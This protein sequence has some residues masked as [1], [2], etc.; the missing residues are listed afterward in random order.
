MII[1][2]PIQLFIYLVYL[3][4]WHLEDINHVKYFIKIVTETF[5]CIVSQCLKAWAWSMIRLN[6]SAITDLFQNI[7]NS[8]ILS[9]ASDCAE[10]LEQYGSTSQKWLSTILAQTRNMGDT[11][12]VVYTSKL[13]FT[14]KR[15]R[16]SSAPVKLDALKA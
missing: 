16:I 8:I 1:F 3:Y 12:S 9:A 10:I 15:K 13:C 2:W 11:S 5:L 4:L 6:H 14:G 7:F